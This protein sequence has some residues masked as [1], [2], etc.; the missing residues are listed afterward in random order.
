MIASFV[1]IMPT[2]PAQPR[3]PAIERLAEMLAVRRQL[4]AEKVAVENA[5]RLLEDAMLNPRSLSHLPTIL[6]SVF[7][8]ARENR[9]LRLAPLALSNV[10]G[11]S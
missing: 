5:A 4:N 11:N 9:N 2:R 3:P 7:G 8:L 6:G 1:A 10:T